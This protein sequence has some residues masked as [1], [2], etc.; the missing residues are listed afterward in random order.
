MTPPQHIYL[1][2]VLLDGRQETLS[3][4]RLLQDNYVHAAVNTSAHSPLY[5][6]KHLAYAAESYRKLYG[7]VPQFDTMQLREG[8]AALLDADRMPRLGN[9]VRI[10]L[11]PSQRSGD[12][13]PDLLAMA[14]HSTIY[15]GYELISIR[16]KAILTNYEIP[17]CGHRTAV[18]LTTSRY[19]QAFAE[20][21]GCHV[22][23]HCN[24]AERLISCGEYPVFLARDGAL[25]TPPAETFPACTERDLM[26][27]ACS[28][29][30]IPHHGTQHRRLGNPRRRRTDGLQPYG[31]PK[32][33]LAGKLLLLQP[34]RPAHRKGAPYRYGRGAASLTPAPAPTRSS[35]PRPDTGI[36]HAEK[37]QRP[38]KT[39][40]GTYC[41]RCGT[42]DA[43]STGFCRKPHI[44]G[45][46]LR[47]HQKQG[48]IRIRTGP[49]ISVRIAYR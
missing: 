32:P 13:M 2:G 28:L 36:S 38:E 22:A 41:L 20:R 34:A 7:T 19:M 23:L 43:A 6:E 45:R 40:R 4:Q 10:Y 16:P 46:A 48:P 15:R 39:D 26:F 21:T 49:D 8:I 27:R 24:R 18:S 44:S 1:N 47:P 11:L 42:R 17:F 33:S 3:A 5:L 9:I 35:G 30:G 12:A 25:F 14:D 31:A 37:E 29:A